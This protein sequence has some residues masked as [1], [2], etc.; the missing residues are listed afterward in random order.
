[1]ISMSRF[2]C[3]MMVPC[4]IAF[5]ACGNDSGSSSSDNVE[6]FIGQKYYIALDE[7]NKTMMV[8]NIDYRCEVENDNYVFVKDEKSNQN[9]RDYLFMGDTL[10]L[11]YDVG[12]SVFGSVF[13]G[14]ENGKI[15]GKW[16]KLTTCTYSQEDNSIGCIGDSVY[17]YTFTQ[18]AFDNWYNTD[19]LIYYYTFTQDTLYISGTDLQGKEV[20]VNAPQEDGYDD[21][22]GSEFVKSVFEHLQMDILGNTPAPW[23]AFQKPRCGN[24]R[25]NIEDAAQEMQV[26]IVSRDKNHISFVYDGT[27]YELDITNASHLWYSRGTRTE[28]S[29]TL[30]SDKGSCSLT[31][32]GDVID[33]APEICSAENAEYLQ[34]ATYY[35]NNGNPLFY[36]ARDY[37]TGNHEEFIN[38]L[39]DL[40]DK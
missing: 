14:G 8:Y 5:Y 22:T 27:S 6:G 30:K 1:M 19:S 35:D 17:Y 9:K 7:A 16:K 2:L 33:D 25:C 11:L 32:M 18:D 37:S 28:L 13:V 20:D 34:L 10:V 23:T 15:K 24:G 4:A 21:Y 26:T 29:A 12:E 40:N 36:G 38:C 31:Y 3:G 39:H